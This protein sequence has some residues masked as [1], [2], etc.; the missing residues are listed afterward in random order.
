MRSI[1]RQFWLQGKIR[2]NTIC[3]SVV[4]T[5]SLDAKEWANFPEEYFTPVEKIVDTVV[6][7]VDGKDEKVEVKGQLWGKAVEISGLSHYYREQPEYCDEAMRAV[8]G[9]TDIEM[10][11]T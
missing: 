6:M 4:R 11:E 10:L 7:L 3:P 1:A 9:S 2:V 5:N 8:M